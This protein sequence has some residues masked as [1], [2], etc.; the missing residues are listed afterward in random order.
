MIFSNSVKNNLREILLN[1][2]G[3][4]VL[5][6]FGFFLRVYGL[7]LKSLWFDEAWVLLESQKALAVLF[8]V[9]TEGIHPPLYRLIMHFCLHLGHTELL[10]RMPSAIFSAASIIVGYKIAMLIFNKRVALCTAF[11][12]AVSPFHIYYAQE[13]KGYSLF[14]FLSLLSV[15]LFLRAIKS[16]RTGLW[17]GYTF[18]T[19]LSIY[20]H[21]FG[22]FNILAQNLFLMF[23]YKRY[24]KSIFRKWMVVQVLTFL[25]F[26]PWLFVFIEHFKRVVSTFWIP[27]ITVKNVSNI[28][29]NFT[30][31]YYTLNLNLAFLQFLI[32]IIFLCGL[33]SLIFSRSTDEERINRNPSEG[34]LIA[35]SYLLI[36]VIILVFSKIIRPLYLDRA[37]ISISFLYYIVLAKGIEFFRKN[38]IIFTSAMFLLTIIIAISLNNYYFEKNFRFS[39]GVP[40]VTKQFRQAARYIASSYRN[41][42]IIMLSH[43]SC[44]PSFQY[45][46]PD[47][48]KGRLY[49]DGPASIIDKNDK[50]SEAC[51]KQT[52]NFKTINMGEFKKQADVGVWVVCSHWSD[53]PFISKGLQEW[54]NVYKKKMS[55]KSD[56]FRGM[57][58][59]YFN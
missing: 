34:L 23:S 48:I 55:F 35:L 50:Y 28:F 53:L 45:Y 43:Y 44:W 9:N 54:M 22:I 58:V 39:I 57:D 19:V 13:V 26:A 2:L 41:P 56:R 37:L 14:F 51:F 7:G 38:K 12:I 31:G 5:F 30:A 49:L 46:L 27:T 11:F 29:I 33:W 4:S 3:I 24:G 59:Y 52:F 6:L 47:N 32:G 20:T 16:D 21:Y 1:N 25:L 15:Y 36:P 17:L 8:N 42:D 18:L 40:S 10:V